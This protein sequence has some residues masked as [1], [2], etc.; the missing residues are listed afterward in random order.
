I[1]KNEALEGFTLPKLLWVKNN[2][3]EIFKQAKTF[4]LPKDYVRYCLSGEIHT[5]YSDAAWTL[6]LDVTNKKWSKEICDE[7]G[8]DDSI[9]PPLVKSH[10]PVGTLT[11]EVAKKTGLSS[12]TRV[13]A[14]GA[15]NACGA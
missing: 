7:L 10:H 13:Y 2:E 1:T 12:S 4:L 6:L 11:L 8:L 14:G 5:D 15:D 9:C 3:P